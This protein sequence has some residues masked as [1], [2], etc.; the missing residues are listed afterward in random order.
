[1]FAFTR[2]GD[3]AT[4]A[5]ARSLGAT[6]AGGSNEMPPQLLDAVIIF[7]TVGDLVPL[8]LQAVRKGGRVV[9]AG[10]HLSVTVRRRRLTV[11]GAGVA[12]WQGE[13]TIIS[14]PHN[15][16]PPHLQRES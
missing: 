2:P 14:I 5:F 12:G 11:R 15:P 1:M 16:T 6:W 4:Q 3:A 7:A 10:I 9:C 13:T 8:A